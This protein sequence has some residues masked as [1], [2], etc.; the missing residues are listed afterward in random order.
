MFLYE[1]TLKQKQIDN[2]QE[3]H[4]K[5]WDFKTP[6]IV[7]TF[8]MI[9][10]STTCIYFKGFETFFSCFTFSEIFFSHFLD[11]EIQTTHL[12]ITLMWVLK[13][14][15]RM[16]QKKKEEDPMKWKVC[17]LCKKGFFHQMNIKSTGG[18]L[19]TYKNCMSFW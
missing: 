15:P 6:S 2:K 8:A 9:L 10:L 11:E 17:F 13:Q 3:Q 12:F 7:L 1:T 19:K 14:K 18:K 16:P 4:K 5:W